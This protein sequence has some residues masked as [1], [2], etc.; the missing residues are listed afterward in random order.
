MFDT[1]QHLK[2]RNRTS[3]KKLGRRKTTVPDRIKTAF[4]NDDLIKQPTVGSPKKRR[5]QNK[6]KHNERWGKIGNIL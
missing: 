1:N 3:T 5:G 6:S 4:E 2:K